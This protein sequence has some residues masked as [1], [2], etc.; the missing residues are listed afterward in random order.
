MAQR[1]RRGTTTPL[2]IIPYHLYVVRDAW[3]RKCRDAR[4]LPRYCMVRGCELKIAAVCHDQSTGN[5]RAHR[6]KVRR[7]PSVPAF[8]PHTPSSVSI[9][10]GASRT[11]GCRNVFHFKPK[12]AAALTSSALQPARLTISEDLPADPPKNADPQDQ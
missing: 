11:A 4:V 12:R 5:V 10:P 7:V 3:Q 1:E 2:G 6:S 8:D 9:S